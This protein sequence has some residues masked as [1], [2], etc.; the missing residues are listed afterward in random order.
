MVIW[1]IIGILALLVGILALLGIKLGFDRGIIGGFT[2]PGLIIAMTAIAVVTI[3]VVAVRK[4][5]E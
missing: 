3:I 5:Q 4:K 2:I 1:S